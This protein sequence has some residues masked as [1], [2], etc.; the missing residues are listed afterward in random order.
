MDFILNELTPTEPLMILLSAEMLGRNITLVDEKSGI[1]VYNMDPCIVVGVY[2][3]LNYKACLPIATPET[4]QTDNSGNR[5]PTTR[6]SS[7]RSDS[8][9][10]RQKQEQRQDHEGEKCDL[11]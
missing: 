7:A 9:P 4:Q 6:N 1:S 2:G 10:E 5:A 8:K 3:N 11:S